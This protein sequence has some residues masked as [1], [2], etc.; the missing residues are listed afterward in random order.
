ML[1]ILVFSL[2]SCF[3]DTE[4]TPDEIEKEP[5][6]VQ[7]ENEIST[8]YETASKGCVAVYATT[9]NEGSIGSGVIYKEEN[10][11]YYVVTNNHVVEDM[12]TFRIYRGGARYYRASLVGRDPKNDIAVLTFSLDLFGGDEIYVHDI[13]SYKED[14]IKP[15]QTTIAIGCPLSLDYFNTVSTGVVSRVST[16]IIQTNTEL[17]PGNSGGGLFNLSG[18]LIGINT[19]KEIYTS[20]KND[21]NAVIQIPV[22]GISFAISLDVVKKCIL[23]IEAKND[24]IT[25]PTLGISVMALNRY[26]SNDAYESLIQYLPNTMDQGIIIQEVS[27]GIAKRYGLL[28]H[29]V[30]LTVEGHEVTTLQELSYYLNLK[31]VGDTFTVTIY[32]QSTGKEEE[33]VLKL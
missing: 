17:N 19:E 27:D 6:I 21:N 29:D 33:I 5:T 15:G 24:V 7:I 23:D 18:R 30:F 20:G 13:F 32:R 9:E 16:G 31:M 10:G 25:R 26:I 1:S 28:Q 12:T 2:T 4:K 3:D 8:V 11:M 22:E 14:L